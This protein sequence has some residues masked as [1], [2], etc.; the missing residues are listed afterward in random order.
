MKRSILL[1]L[2]ICVLSLAGC[3]TSAPSEGAGYALLTPS[4]A[5]A[6]FVSRNDAAFARQVAAHNRQCR[7][8][9]GCMK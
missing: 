5:T 3:Q 6:V 4:S 8:D 1:I 9:R 7:K 2:P